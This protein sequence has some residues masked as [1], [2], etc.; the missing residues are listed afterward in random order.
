MDE[1]KPDH[2]E[3]SQKFFQYTVEWMRSSAVSHSLNRLQRVRLNAN[4]VCYLI[5]YAQQ[6]CGRIKKKQFIKLHQVVFAW[7]EEVVEE[8]Q[9]LQ[10][11]IALHQH[12]KMATI[13]GWLHD[14]VD[15]A[16]QM[17]RSLLLEAVPMGSVLRR[18]DQQLLSDAC[19]NLVQYC[20]FS[21][22]S[23][24]DMELAELAVILAGVF[25]DVTEEAAMEAL[26]FQLKKAKLP[27]G[28]A[29]SSQLFL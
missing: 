19:Y 3:M 22:V 7:N 9:R 12:E 28:G 23:L 5:W 8:L 20:K 6:A 1:M 15:I 26:V 2:T 11:M 18:N 24:S 27:S 21:H 14:E 25:D 13:R 10:S 17:E 4:L 29:V 16:H